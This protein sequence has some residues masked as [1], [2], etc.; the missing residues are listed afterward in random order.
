MLSLATPLL[1]QNQASCTFKFFVPPAPFNVS[2][3]ANGIDNS[4]TVV[5]E[6]SSTTLTKAFVRTS[7]GNL[8]FFRVPNAAITVLKKRNSKGV[9]VGYYNL[10]S[11]GGSTGLIRQSSGSWSSLT[12]PNA[13]STSLSGINKN[14]VIVGT[15]QPN[16]GYT[17]G[18]KYSNGTFTNIKF[19]GSVATMPEAINDNGVIVGEYVMGNLENPAQGF[20]LQ[21]GKYTTLNNPFGVG[22]TFLLDI[23]NAG[24]IVALG[25]SAGSTPPDGLF[26]K[27]GVWELISAPQSYE[28]FSNGLNGSDVVTGEA[29]FQSS[30]GNVTW[31]AYTAACQ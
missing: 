25:G 29:N 9:S 30:N 18:F 26:Y 17:Q 21:N 19:P 5:G 27:N 8:T 15:Y 2:F 23:N 24:T 12:H 7:A 16:T 14:G 11:T 22:N 13:T 1:A 28:T 31:K 10:S 20:I 6:A 3:Q 4:N